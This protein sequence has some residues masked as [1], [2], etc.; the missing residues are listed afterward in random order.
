VEADRPRSSDR[1]PA[2]GIIV[3][4]TTDTTSGPAVTDPFPVPRLAS[5][6]EHLRGADALSATAPVVVLAAWVALPLALLALALHGRPAASA[7]SA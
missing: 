6:F 7:S 4:R 1:P 5:H 3:V 2:A